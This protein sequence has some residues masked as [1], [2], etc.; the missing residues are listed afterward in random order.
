MAEPPPRP[1]LFLRP[2]S[3][4]HLRQRAVYLGDVRFDAFRQLDAWFS[5]E[6]G[7]LVRDVLVFIQSIQ[8]T[9]TLELLCDTLAAHLGDKAQRQK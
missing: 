6:L 9:E 1:H 3:H 5:E 8:E 4:G 7:Q 2:G